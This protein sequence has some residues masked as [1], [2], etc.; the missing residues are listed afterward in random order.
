MYRN[1][2]LIKM[3]DSLAYLGGSLTLWPVLHVL[4]STLHCK[5]VFSKC[6]LP[7]ISYIQAYLSSLLLYS[8]FPLKFDIHGN[9]PLTN[10][11]LRLS[12]AEMIGSL[13]D[14]RNTMFSYDRASIQYRKPLS[15]RDLYGLPSASVER[16]MPRK[17][18]RLRRQAAQLKGK[19]PNLTDVN[20][21]DKWSR[22]I[23]PIAFSFFNLVYW[24][25]YVH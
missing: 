5:N 2:M 16:P 19:I 15:G 25:Y 8:F 24:L 21:I 12:G 20:A 13:G 23:F 22:A 7:F 18:S 9:I 1:S 17:K 11:D 14:P 6:L 10:L 3:R 4:Q